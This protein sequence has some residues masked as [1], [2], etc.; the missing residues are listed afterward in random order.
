MPQNDSSWRMEGSRWVKVTSPTSEV[1]NISSKT[2]PKINNDFSQKEEIKISEQKA[3]I[4]NSLKPETDL[5][6][7]NEFFKSLDL[8]PEDL[9][10]GTTPEDIENRCVDLVKTYIGGS[11]SNISLAD[12]VVTRISGGLTNQLYRVHLK[13]TVKRVEN[14]IYPDEPSDVAIKIYQVCY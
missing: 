4:V 8:K 12:V 2:K 13:D 1:N 9:I 11:W 3:E 14:N 10:R 6:N 7:N 5:N